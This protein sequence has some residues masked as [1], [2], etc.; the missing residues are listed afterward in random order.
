LSLS[1]TFVSLVIY[2]NAKI[3]YIIVKL[4][5][6][7]TIFSSL[8]NKDK[9]VAV[10][11]LIKGSTP[12][13]DFFF[14]TVLSVLTATFGLLLNNAAVIIGS[15]LIAPILYPVLSL[16][17]GIIM[18]D[19]KVISRSFWTITK[20]VSL[21]V[22]ATFLATLLFSTQFSETTTEIASRAHPSLTYV[23]IAII[24]GFAASFALVKPQLNETLPGVAIS[25]ALI[26]PLAVTGIGIARFNW[27]LIS[28]SFLL[29][30]VNTVG[31][32]FASMI[33][34]SLMN[35]YAQRYKADITIKKEETKIRRDIK[36][37]KK[38]ST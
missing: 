5:M 8:T 6:A 15:M 30:L 33:T 35:F 9:V 19:F 34:F 11:R 25:V 10:D 37:A 31:V 28:G 17:L 21:G 12:S 24:A 29:F 7:I 2:L 27:N 26:P 16:S 32:V 14:M 13:Q 3:A 38:R 1:S 23:I 22:T 4:S 20:S 18:S 36:K